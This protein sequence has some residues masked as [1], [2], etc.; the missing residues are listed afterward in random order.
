MYKRQVNAQ[1]SCSSCNYTSLPALTAT[2]ARRC[3]AEVLDAPPA[4]QGTPSARTAGETKGNGRFRAVLAASYRHMWA[5]GSLA[6][7]PAFCAMEGSPPLSRRPRSAR[8]WRSGHEACVFQPWVHARPLPRPSVC[9]TARAGGQARP[10][11]G[12]QE[13]RAATSSTW[14]RAPTG[15]CVDPLPLLQELSLIHI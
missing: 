6:G 2:K 1:V 3:P 12:R 8:R 14:R 15:F 7:A 13:Q 9:V 4:P 5:R 11:H 10:Y